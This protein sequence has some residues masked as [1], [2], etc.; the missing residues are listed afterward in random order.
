MVLSLGSRKLVL[1][2]HT[3]EEPIG[4]VG[5]PPRVIFAP[6]ISSTSTPA[7]TTGNGFTEIV[8][9]SLSLQP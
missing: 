2:L 8:I 9:V 1:G 5:K 7:S 3:N 6:Y 4:P